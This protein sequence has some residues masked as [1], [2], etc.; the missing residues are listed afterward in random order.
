MKSNGWDEDELVRWGGEAGICVHRPPRRPATEFRHNYETD[1]GRFLVRRPA[2]VIEPGSVTEL[3]AAM[4]ALGERTIGYKLRGAG[5]SSGGQVLI[6]GGVVI[7][8]SGLRG[9]VDHGDTV[10]VLGGTTWLEV[11]EH[12]HPRRRPPVLTDN[13]RTTV[14]GTLAVGGIGDTSIHDG[15]QIASVIE[16]DWVAPDGT[17]R[18][19]TQ[20]DEELGFVLAGRGQLGAIARVRLPTIARP[21]LLAGHIAAWTSVD[22]YLEAAAVIRRERSYEVVRATLFWRADGSTAV[23]AIL[24][25]FVDEEPPADDPGLAPLRCTTSAVIPAS[26]RLASQRVDPVASWD[27][28]CPALELALPLDDRGVAAWREIE[29][30]I[31]ASGLRDVLPDGVALAVVAAADARLPLAPLP[32]AQNGMFVAL[33][34]QVATPSDAVRWLPV[35][36]ELADI[37]LACGGR[38]YLMS[39]E[40]DRPDFL[41]RQF[42]GALGRFRELKRWHDPA[43]VCNPGLL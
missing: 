27:Y 25:N 21:P 38:I 14:A 13:L 32:V 43:G 37:A 5:H 33:R 15:L 17:S 39:I 29:R 12:L 36:H 30:R 11:A 40:L 22:A 4:R 34:P 8:L 31:V 3:A 26:D 42:G 10:D 19:L 1:F 35:L 6:E 9:I 41:D 18:T 7:E 16:L 20:A 24:A 23:R 2:L 28:V